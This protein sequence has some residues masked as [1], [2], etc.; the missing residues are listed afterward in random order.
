MP[1]E[2]LLPNTCHPVRN[3]A[4]FTSCNQY[5]VAFAYNGITVITG[6]IHSIT[7]FNYDSFKIN[8][9]IEYIKY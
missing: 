3:S 1:T 8:T 2:C 7:F 6:I 5:I 9:I 4:V